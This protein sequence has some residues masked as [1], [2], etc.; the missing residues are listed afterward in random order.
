MGLGLGLVFMEMPSCVYQCQ[1]PSTSYRILSLGFWKYRTAIRQ[2]LHLS[3][4]FLR[5]Y[6]SDSNIACLVV[7]K[8]NFSRDLD[9]SKWETHTDVFW[10]PQRLFDAVH[11]SWIV[12]PSPLTD[13][14]S[15][16]YWQLLWQI[17]DNISLIWTLIETTKLMFIFWSRW[18]LRWRSIS[19]QNRGY[20]SGLNTS[21]GSRNRWN[22]S[23][24]FSSCSLNDLPI[25]MTP[26]K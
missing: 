11:S 8:K 6:C 26:S 3:M 16:Q 25:T 9:S 20:F 14:D 1:Q 19:L 12:C 24:K 13:K 21:F 10:I 23:G 15:A 5:E 7:Y 2:H 18:H 22:I 17:H 4:H